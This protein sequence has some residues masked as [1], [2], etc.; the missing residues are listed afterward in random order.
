[1]T[2]Y[3]QNVDEKKERKREKKRRGITVKREKKR[4]DESMIEGKLAI[5]WFLGG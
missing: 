4:D 3:R 2:R 5:E 1:M